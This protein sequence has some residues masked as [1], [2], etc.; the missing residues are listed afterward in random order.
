MGR[1]AGNATIDQA[2][3]RQLMQT[4]ARSQTRPKRQFQTPEWVDHSFVLPD[5][6]TPTS[7]VAGSHHVVPS[8]RVVTPD[9]LPP[10]ERP[11]TA[12]VDFAAV[13]RRADVGRRARLLTTA[14]LLVAVLA[15]VVFQVTA[16]PVAAVCAILAAIVAI[17]GSATRVVLNR[18]PVPY[19]PG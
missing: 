17:G 5:Q 3:M 6:Q 13:V 1:T 19:L 11:A 12:D 14:A 2:R 9:P 8:P 4:E 18:A 10:F 16:A 15:I 7:M